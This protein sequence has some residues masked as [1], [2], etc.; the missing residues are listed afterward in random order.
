MW[1]GWESCGPRRCYSKCWVSGSV[2]GFG[3]CGWAQ[4]LFPEMF[5][6]GKWPL[7]GVTR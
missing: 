3:I 5:V 6:T 1:R 2:E 7:S 4:A